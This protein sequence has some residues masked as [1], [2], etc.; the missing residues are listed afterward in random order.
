MI[1]S[2]RHILF[3]TTV[4]ILFAAISEAG[5]ASRQ[6]PGS[7]VKNF[8]D[9]AVDKILDLTGDHGIKT[10]AASAA[11]CQA[12]LINQAALDKSQGG[13]VRDWASDFK[14]VVV[15]CK[16]PTPSGCIDNPLEDYQQERLKNSQYNAI[17]FVESHGLYHTVPTEGSGEKE[18]KPELALD[19]KYHVSGIGFMINE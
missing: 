9:W 12:C 18:K 4:I 11:A 8:W 13:M 2:K 14:R 1:F 5:V 15:F 16:E 6:N 3:I 10:E 7:T 19:G 17:V